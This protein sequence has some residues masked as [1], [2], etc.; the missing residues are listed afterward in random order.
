M[1]WKMA[2]VAVGILAILWAT[3]FDFQGAKA[4]ITGLAQDNAESATGGS[5]R[6][7]WGS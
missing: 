3:G 5:L 6:S 4:S 2:L 7:D 1:L